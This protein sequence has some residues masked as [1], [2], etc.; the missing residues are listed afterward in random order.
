MLQMLSSTIRNTSLYPWRF[1][2][3]RFGDSLRTRPLRVSGIKETVKEG[4]QSIQ[5]NLGKY[6]DISV[7]ARFNMI[8]RWPCS[9][10]ANPIH[11]CIRCR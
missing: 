6:F 5:F 1:F 8:Q 7:V 10:G 11:V 3:H 9:R 2:R 4:H